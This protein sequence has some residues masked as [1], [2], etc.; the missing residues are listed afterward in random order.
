M[1]TRRLLNLNAVEV[2]GRAITN[3]SEAVRYRAETN[4]QGT[5]AGHEALYD[6]H[7]DL[8]EAVWD[9]NNYLYPPRQELLTD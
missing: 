6:A 9:L 3:R 5:G 8:L 4:Q 7:H 1:T 2:L